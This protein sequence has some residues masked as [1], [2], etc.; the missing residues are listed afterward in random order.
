MAATKTPTPRSKPVLYWFLGLAALTLAFGVVV[1]FQE[2]RANRKKPAP[3]LMYVAASLKAPLEQIAAEYLQATGQRVELSSGGSHTL[4][5]NIAITKR[6]D[7]YLPADDSYLALAREKNLIG[8]TFPVTEQSVVLA[9]PKGN[10]KR[11]RTLGDLGAP[12]I[13]LSQANPETAAIGKLLRSAMETDGFWLT[14]SNRIVIF[15]PTVVDAANDVKLGAVDAAFVWDSMERQYPELE[16]IR[17]S[18]LSAVRA[19][20]AVAVLTDSEQP[21]AALQLARF[22]ASDRGREHF[23]NSGFVV[24]PSQHVTHHVAEAQK[25]TDKLLMPRDG[26]GE[27]SV[28]YE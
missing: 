27:H 13:R 18:A 16:F 5:A 25:L 24:T 17:M 8:E 26:R 2:A 10:P 19:K 11:L 7:L 3:L 12:S 21:E 4:L 22:I 14:L 20:V 1:M 9:V 23:S 28:L 15:R 6:G